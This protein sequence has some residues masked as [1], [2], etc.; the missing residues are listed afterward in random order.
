MM[1]RMT[2]DSGLLAVR[3]D[4]WPGLE[5]II[6]KRGVAIAATEIAGA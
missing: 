3:R 2:P 5:T 6:R 1:L 4:W